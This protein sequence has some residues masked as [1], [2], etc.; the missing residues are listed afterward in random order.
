MNYVFGSYKHDLARF[1]ANYR[2]DLRDTADG[3]PLG[4]H[5]D[6]VL[7]I[8]DAQ[9]DRITEAMAMGLVDPCRFAIV[10]SLEATLFAAVHAYD[11]ENFEAYVDALPAQVYVEA[12]PWDGV[13]RPHIVLVGIPEWTREAM[14]QLRDGWAALLPEWARAYDQKFRR[15]RSAE[16]VRAL[17]DDPD[18]AL[19]PYGNLLPAAVMKAL[20]DGIRVAAASV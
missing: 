14:D 7:Y 17:A 13:R 3:A 6:K 11:R 12:H 1:A 18:L 10:L 9:P 4:N 16:I 20:R 2:G 8:C 19:N 5:R 15:R